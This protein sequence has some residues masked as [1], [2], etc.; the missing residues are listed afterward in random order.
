MQA[1]SDQKHSKSLPTKEM[2]HLQMVTTCNLGSILKSSTTFFQYTLPRNY[3]YFSS[4]LPYI[5]NSLLF[6]SLLL[7]KLSSSSSCSCCTRGGKP[8]PLLL[9]F[10]TT[11]PNFLLFSTLS[12]S[13]QQR[14]KYLFLDLHQPPLQS[15]YS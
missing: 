2:P 13:L 5:P 10:T 11:T 12:F 7:N 4:S 14:S 8:L 3:L 9:G 15:P 6:Y 1:S